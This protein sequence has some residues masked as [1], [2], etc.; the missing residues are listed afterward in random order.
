MKKRPYVKKGVWYLGKGRRE[1][2]F[3]LACPLLGAAAGPVLKKV[4]APLLTRVF[5]KIVRR[6][7]RRKRRRR[8]IYRR[9]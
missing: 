2:F 6:G 5:K 4:A 8:I 3:P 7:S 1:R 9:F